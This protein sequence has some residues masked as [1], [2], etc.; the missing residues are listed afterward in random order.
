[1]ERSS[2]AEGTSTKLIS[3][4]IGLIGQD[5]SRVVRL[6]A[7]LGLNLRKK[8]KRSKEILSRN[9]EHYTDQQNCN[10]SPNFAVQS[11]H[12]LFLM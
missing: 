7:V 6:F 1:M 2:T 11:F 3:C 12:L 10:K 4:D 5:S 8:E 9:V